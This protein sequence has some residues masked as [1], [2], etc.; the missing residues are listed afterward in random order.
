MFASQTA[1]VF[2]LQ[3]LFFVKMPAQKGDYDRRGKGD[4]VDGQNRQQFAV[5]FSGQMGAV[6]ARLSIDHDDGEV[7]DVEAIAVFSKEPQKRRGQEAMAQAF[8]V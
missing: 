1:K 6:Q 5:Q 4:A 8:L 7:A 2:E 3:P